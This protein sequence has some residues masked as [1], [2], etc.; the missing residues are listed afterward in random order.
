MKN[1][2][3]TRQMGFLT[4]KHW[5][6]R[7]IHIFGCGGLG[8]P[9]ALI[10]GK[11]GAEKI[12]L[13]DK[14]IVEDI[15]VNNQLFG[16]KDINQPKVDA[17]KNNVEMLTPMELSQFET[18]NGDIMNID[19]DSLV[20]KNDDIVILSLDSNEVRTHIYKELKSHNFFGLIVDP[21]MAGLVFSVYT[22]FD[23]GLWETGY[24][25]FTPSD[26]SVPE[27]VCT[28]KAIAFN[29][30]GCASVASSLVYKYLRNELK[31]TEHYQMDM[32]NSI[33]VP[34]IQ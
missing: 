14:D 11:M 5:E 23:K 32:K 2:Y 10:L 28:E 29:T 21:R 24:K 13:Y 34:L 18:V 20:I 26:D 3:L 33:F 4:S 7:T 17:V 8:S 12:V 25:H 22:T 1:T 19:F 16:L 6:G 31:Q 15:N 30:F 27:G 9:L